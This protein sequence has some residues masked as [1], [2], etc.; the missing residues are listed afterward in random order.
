DGSELILE[1]EDFE[2]VINT[3]PELTPPPP[4]EESGAFSCP[5]RAAL[6][7]FDAD[8]KPI[9]VGLAQLACPV[10]SYLRGADFGKSKPAC[11]RIASRFYV[12]RAAIERSP[13]AS[14]PNLYLGTA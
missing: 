10:G 6:S 5:P 14:Q 2:G 3:E 1:D 13:E 4:V 9:C 7:G 8:G 11:V 12:R